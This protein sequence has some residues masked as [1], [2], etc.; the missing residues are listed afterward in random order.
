M[1]LYDRIDEREIGGRIVYKF[2]GKELKLTPAPYRQV[3]KGIMMV[4]LGSKQFQKISDDDNFIGNI[5]DIFDKN[6]PQ[7]I[8]IMFDKSLNPFLDL[9]W[10]EANMI[11][12]LGKEIFKDIIEI[13]GLTDFFSQKGAKDSTPNFLG[14]TFNPSKSK[15]ENTT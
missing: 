9:E 6:L 2:K 7:M 11:I 5:V 14:R 3:K 15:P 12:P 13:N 4:L 8:L 10:I 1:P